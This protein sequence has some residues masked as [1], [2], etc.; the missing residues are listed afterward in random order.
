MEL[1]P[2]QLFFRRFTDLYRPLIAKV[3]GVLAEGGL[4]V[5][6][7]S[8]LRI[9]AEEGEMTPAELAFRQNVEK[10]TVSRNLQQLHE[11]GLIDF[12]AGRDRREKILFL[13]EEG[14][15]VYDQARDA[16]SAVEEEVLRGIPREDQM[17]MAEFFSLIRKNLID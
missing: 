16:V 1:L 13:T 10:P 4:T 14:R 12:K 11:R 9:I 6:H 7:W 17:R 5:P 15:A 8:V 2:H 3:G